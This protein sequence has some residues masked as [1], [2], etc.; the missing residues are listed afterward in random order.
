MTAAYQVPRHH[1]NLYKE[2]IVN[3]PC[4]RDPGFSQEVF[5][6]LYSESPKELPP[7]PGNATRRAMHE[8]IS[9]LP[10]F[11]TLRH[12]T[13]RDPMWAAIATQ[14]MG[15]AI[16]DKMP[17]SIN[18]DRANSILEGLKDLQEQSGTDAFDQPLQQAKKALEAAISKDEA[19][20]QS[21]D[22]SSIRHALRGA[23]EDAGQDI[24]QAESALSLLGYGIGNTPGQPNSASNPELALELA[25]KVKSSSQL[26]KIIE[27]AGRL[28]GVARAKKASRSEYA[29]SEVVGVEQTNDMPHLLGSELALLN[30]PDLSDDLL[31]RLIEKR[32][33]GYKMAGKEK[34]SKGPII[35]MLDQSGSM[36]DHSKDTWAKAIALAIYDAARADN[37]A[38]G[39]VSYDGGVRQ[40][41]MIASPTDMLDAIS[42]RADGYATDY[43]KAMYKCLEMCTAVKADV[44]HLTDGSAPTHD[45]A[46]A[47]E[48]ADALGAHVYG[49]G[50]G[51]VGPALKAWSHTSTQITD[52]SKDSA[53]M[54]LIFGEGGV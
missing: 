10:E 27:L 2:Q 14:H 6:R 5:H 53:A 21:L 51:I 46:A 41:R 9:Q 40:A 29:R 43:T 52:V 32:A 26:S 38:F 50:I 36:S 20:A 44:V 8:L 37:R 19:N 31:I 1:S 7:A 22:E 47:L 4:T 13:T 54:D 35:L 25:R 11:E 23:I 45:A 17:R 12:S 34:L 49:I 28:I 33:L 24:A 42:E 15:K 39:V 18:V 30:D 3:E 48:R 16:S